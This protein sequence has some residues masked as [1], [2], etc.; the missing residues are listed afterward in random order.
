MVLQ[1]FDEVLD[2]AQKSG[3]PSQ[4]PDVTVSAA[5]SEPKSNRSSARN[6]SGSTGTARNSRHEENGRLTTGIQL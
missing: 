3:P 2:E 1:T 6:S 5:S 4:T